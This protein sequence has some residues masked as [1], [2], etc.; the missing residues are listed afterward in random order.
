MLSYAII[1]NTIGILDKKDVSFSEKTRVSFQFINLLISLKSFSA[2]MEVLSIIPSSHLG[3]IYLS[4]EEYNTKYYE[5]VDCS[6]GSITR[7]LQYF[8][9]FKAKYT[10]DPKAN[11]FKVLLRN[12]LKGLYRMLEYNPDDFRPIIAHWSFDMASKLN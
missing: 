10:T 7:E 8:H 11:Y 12:N 5:H 2:A 6:V 4:M 9:T 1:V 3:Y